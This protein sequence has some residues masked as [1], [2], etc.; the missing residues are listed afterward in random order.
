MKKGFTLLELMIAVTIFAG[1]II[2]SIGAIAS[3]STYSKVNDDKKE[4]TKVTQYTRDQFMKDFSS[5]NT[6]LPSIIPLPDNYVI[7][8]D[9]TILGRT[10]LP[11]DP[12][13]SHYITRNPYIVIPTF[14]SDG[15]SNKTNVTAYVFGPQITGYSRILYY[16]TYQDCLVTTHSTMPGL[17]YYLIDC[18]KFAPLPSGMDPSGSFDLTTFSD[19]FNGKY[20]IDLQSSQSAWNYVNSTHTISFDFYFKPNNDEYLNYQCSATYSLPYTRK[21]GCHKFELTMNTKTW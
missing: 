20:V 10:A 18:G 15:S 12:N 19:F 6:A 11:T 16:K 13:R 3:T 17:S 2:M 5:I 1:L 21:E 9:T 4:A 14:A 7:Y 8:D